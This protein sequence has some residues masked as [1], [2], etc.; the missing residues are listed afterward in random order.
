MSNFYLGKKYLGKVLQQKFQTLNNS[1]VEMLCLTKFLN[2][3]TLAAIFLTWL[4]CDALSMWFNW[5]IKIEGHVDMSC[6]SIAWS[7]TEKMYIE[8]KNEF[9][10]SWCPAST[11]YRFPHIYMYYLFL[12]LLYL[13]FFAA[14]S[15]LLVHFF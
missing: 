8:L 2:H 5:S 4:S 11:V 9:L 6:L 12:L 1:F 15:L 7:I 14:A 3:V 10:L 13:L